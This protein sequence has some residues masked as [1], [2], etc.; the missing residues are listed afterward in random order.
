MVLGLEAKL[1]SAHTRWDFTSEEQGKIDGLVLAAMKRWGKFEI[2]DSEECHDRKYDPGWRNINDRY[3]SGLKYLVIE[4]AVVT[5]GKES[6][7]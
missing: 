3:A 4:E 1:D 7:E 5:A 2:N 6:K